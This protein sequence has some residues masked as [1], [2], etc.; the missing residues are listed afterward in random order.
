MKRLLAVR[1]G[2]AAATTAAMVLLIGGGYAIAGGGDTVNACVQKH[3]RVLY[4]APCHRGDRSVSWGKLGPQ[5]PPGMQGV[6]GATGPAGSTGATGPKGA[7]GSA[8]PQGD[9]GPVGGPGP[10]GP[11]AGYSNSD[12]SGNGT[13]I[14]SGGYTT[15]LGLTVPVGHYVV[16]AKTLAGNVAAAGDTVFC[17]LGDPDSN[18]A[19][20][21]GASTTPS[22]PYQTVTVT[23]SIAT[24]SLGTI[25]LNCKDSDASN[26]MSMYFTHITA[27]LVGDVTG[28][29]GQASAVSARSPLRQR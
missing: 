13:A 28:A 22:A 25:K 19:D 21:G 29:S 14:N 11:S 9:T 5:G 3:S 4:A 27:T 2:R 20:W 10:T 18:V 15:V 16:T 6:P 1:G 12:I 7:T 17:W 24:H 23:A 26:R 8:G